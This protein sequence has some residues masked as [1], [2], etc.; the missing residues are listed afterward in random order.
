MGNMSQI[1]DHILPPE[2][3]EEFGIGISDFDPLLRGGEIEA[4][5]IDAAEGLRGGGCG[6]CCHGSFP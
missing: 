1:T 2:G 6:L 5:G 3:R 4:F